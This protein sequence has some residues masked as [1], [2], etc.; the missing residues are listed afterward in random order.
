MNTLLS[1]NDILHVLGGVKTYIDSSIEQAIDSIKQTLG[2]A[3]SKGVSNQIAASDDGLATSGA[4]YDYVSKHNRNIVVLTLQEY[5]NLSDTEK[6]NGTL[7][8]ISA[9][10]QNITD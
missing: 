10:Q 2:G 4:V 8:A 5:N 1:Y 3:A 6:T 9:S 7:Y